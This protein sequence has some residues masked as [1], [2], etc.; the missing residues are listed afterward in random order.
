MQLMQLGNG[1]SDT[2]MKNTCPLGIGLEKKT[3]SIRRIF[4]LLLVFGFWLKLLFPT[5][6]QL[7]DYHLKL[8]KTNEKGELLVF[9]K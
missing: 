9:G 1:T 5:L 4:F 6:L 3:L 8:P 2:A 7:N